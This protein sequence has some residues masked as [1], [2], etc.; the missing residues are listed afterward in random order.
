MHRRGFMSAIGALGTSVF[1]CAS[2]DPGGAP[3][4]AAPAPA[5]RVGD[6]RVYRWRDG[7]REPIVWEETHEVT[8]ANPQSVTVR[9]TAR[10]P[11]VDVERVE[12]WVAPGVVRVG[13]LFALETRNFDPPLSRYRF[14]L[15]PGER[16][17][18]K[19]RDPNEPPGPYGLIDYYAIVGGYEPVETPAGRFDALRLRV[20]IRLDDEAFWR[21]PTECNYLVWYAPAIGASVRELRQADYQEKGSS[22]FDAFSRVRSQ[23][24]QLELVAFARGAG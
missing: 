13:A 19:V 16:W 10:G 5:Y 8:A 11:T 6:R 21:Y 7:F 17:S 4:P 23:Y 20:F 18:Q 12:Q 24:A 9:V 3:G 14:P 2:F 1:G 15:T 22:R